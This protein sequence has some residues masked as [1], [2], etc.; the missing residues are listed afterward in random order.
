MWS[1]KRAV[2]RRNLA[3][4]HYRAPR[5]ATLR[6]VPLPPD[7]YASLA[8]LT[9]PSKRLC[10]IL[11]CGLSLLTLAAGLMLLTGC[12]REPA[13]SDPR[14]ASLAPGKRE[15]PLRPNVIIVSIDTLRADHLSSYGYARP[16][17]PTIDALGASGVRF[18]N[19]MAEAPWTLPSHMTLMSGLHPRSHGTTRF[20]RRLPNEI[21][22]LAETLQRA[23]YRTFAYTTGGLLGSTY[24]FGRG[25]DTYYEKLRPLR[26]LVARAIAEIEGLAPDERYF[27]FLQTF[28]VHCPYQANARF[29]QEFVSAP[30]ADHIDTA[31]KCS[32]DYLEMGIS[33]GQTRFLAEMYDAGI[34]QA[35]G[36]LNEL[37]GF[38]L[39]RRAFRETIF[40]LLSDHGEE[41]GEHGSLGHGHSLYEEALRIPLLIMAPGLTPRVVEERVGLV[42]VMPTV[43]DLL[44]IPPPAM[45]GRSLVSLLRGE[46]DAEEERG[47]GASARPHFAETTSNRVHLRSVLA[48]NWKLI[49]DVNTDEVELFDLAR[50]P[51]EQ[52]NV[53]AASPERARTLRQRLDAHFDSLTPP[54][55]IP[56]RPGPENLEQ[57]RALGYID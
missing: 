3:R 26:G 15:P 6:T 35:N 41:F 57:L 37:V 10:S 9:Q 38:L 23:G 50:D 51:G 28:E 44:S 17:S 13:E 22:T 12:G 20:G 18:A 7:P 40:I 30:P 45:Q 24:G 32:K 29:T 43:L 49:L 19:A 54:P 53:A 5:D 1:R 36:P 14:G 42:D 4:V 31:G 16:T 33:E 21:P 56:T 34:R 25:F 2:P 48:E 11:G 8:R 47:G 52:S 55:E 39:A 46:L 27:L